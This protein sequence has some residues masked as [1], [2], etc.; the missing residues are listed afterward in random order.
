MIS[1]ELIVPSSPEKMGKTDYSAKELL[2]ISLQAYI[3]NIRSSNQSFHESEF[4]FRFGTKSSNFYGRPFSKIDYDHVIQKLVAEGFETKNNAGQY[5]LRVQCEKY[6]DQY[7][8]QT[9]NK[10]LRVEIRGLPLIQKLWK[11]NQLQ[12]VMNDPVNRNNYYQSV[13]FISKTNSRSTNKVW[14][15][16]DFPEFRFRACHNT[17]HHLKHT[18]PQATV[19][20]NEWSRSKKFFRYLNRVTFKHP[21]FPLRVDLSIVKMNQ[22]VKKNQPSYTFDMES[23][24]VLTTNDVKYEI[25]IELDNK[26]IAT[27]VDKYPDAATLMVHVRKVIMM[28]LSGLQTTNFPVSYKEQSEIAQQYLWLTHEIPEKKAISILKKHPFPTKEDRYSSSSFSRKLPVEDNIDNDEDKKEDPMFDEND[29]DDQRLI[30]IFGG[31]HTGGGISVSGNGNGGGHTGGGG[32]SVSGN[33]NGV[34]EKDIAS[35]KIIELLHRYPERIDFIGPGCFTLQKENIINP[36]SYPNVDAPNIRTNYCV[37]DKAD[38]DRVLLFI[39]PSTGKIYFIDH[40]LNIMFTGLRCKDSELYNS[41]LDG[42]LIRHNAKD[43]YYNLFAAFDIYFIHSKDVRDLAFIRE[44]QQQEEGEGCGEEKPKPDRYHLMKMFVKDLMK[45]IEQIGDKKSA[46]Q[47][48]IKQFYYGSTTSIFQSCAKLLEQ[49]NH[50][51]YPYKT[52]GLIFTPMSF[53]VGG[54]HPDTASTNRHSYYSWK[55]LF[56]W[57]P[58]QYNTIDFLVDV[59]R[60]PSNHELVST[61]YV[62]GQIV[63]YKTLLL[64]TTYS[65]RKDGYTN[66]FAKMVN[67]DFSFPTGNEDF[68]STDDKFGNLND[69]NNNNKSSKQFFYKEFEPSDYDDSLRAKFCYV[70][71]KQDENF[72]PQMFTMEGDAFDKGTIVE[73]AF[74]MS[75]PVEEWRWKPLRIRH[76][77]T[78]L[79]RQNSPFAANSYRVANN[80]WQAIHQFIDEKMISTGSEIMLE[81]S[82]EISSSDNDNNRI[83]NTQYYYK[84]QSLPVEESYTVALRDFHNLGVKSMLIR[85][86]TIES[87]QKTLIDYAVGKAGDLPKWIQYHVKFVL[88]VDLAKDNIENNINGACA[89]YLNAVRDFKQVPGALFLH[90]NSELNIRDGSAFVAS[91]EKDRIIADAVFGHGPKDADIIG[92]GVVPFYGVAYRGFEIS[93]CQFALHYFFRNH[94]SLLGFIRNLCECTAVNGYFIATC[95][96]GERVFRMLNVHKRVKEGKSYSIYRGTNRKIWEITKKYKNEGVVYPDDHGCVGYRVD[97]FQESIQETF[98]EYLVH[99]PYFQRMMKNFGFELVGNAEAAERGLPSTGEGGTGFF[100]DVFEHYRKQKTDDY[101]GKMMQMSDE[102]KEISFL[103]RYMVFKKMFEIN[104]VD[105]L[106]KRLLEEIDAELSDK[107]FLD[108]SFPS[109]LPPGSSS[110]DDLP[111]DSNEQLSM[112]KRKSKKAKVKYEWQSLFDDSS[113]SI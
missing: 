83:T 105:K 8:R 42:E 14:Y 111:S 20:I 93:S 108:S 3:D 84:E 71:L 87:V 78:A 95:F 53:G 92:K 21:D 31:G 85:A 65:Y 88:G 11:T 19:L 110:S 43:E 104:N 39:A 17:E 24:K 44:K 86:T 81:S 9:L 28:I 102:E 29:E 61:T 107:D 57:K 7:K 45:S 60:T 66:P 96:D 56:K 6:N 109:E 35:K 46:A 30:Q 113:T 33:G 18:S 27:N 94:R 22:S 41:L 62:N 73:F 52:D 70:A 26:E 47:I 72:N 49:T 74:D 36:A 63:N 99:F 2:D 64:K 32:I 97:V 100:S 89:R 98:A 16:I 77:K 25:E 101:L 38:G 90:A 68:G 54:D 58:P 15:P 80:N 69:N 51:D 5:I 23:S 75:E 55:H 59:V 48:K 10:D 40:G 67:G 13:K 82:N 112:K 50:P 4:E 91:S 79:Y 12:T 1:P 103:N 37:T 34:N 106:E 76:D